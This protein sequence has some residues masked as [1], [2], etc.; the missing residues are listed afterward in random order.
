MYLVT[1]AM[2]TSVTAQKILHPV[3]NNP[4]KFM[5]KTYVTHPKHT[6]VLHSPPSVPLPKVTEPVLPPLSCTTKEPWSPTPKAFWDS[7]SE[8][9]NC[10]DYSTS[11]LPPAPLI[12]VQEVNLE[13]NRT[14]SRCSI[15]AGRCCGS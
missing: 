10:E 4:T 13:Y 2:P 12:P 8:D 6:R 14:G 1:A 15:R 9:D 3:S 11:H 5:S 7:D